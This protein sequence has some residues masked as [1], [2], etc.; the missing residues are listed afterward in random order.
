MSIV[1]VKLLATLSATLIAYAL[2]KA[3]I[4]IFAELTS[5]TRDLPGPKS[6]SLFYGNL[7]ELRED[8][9]SYVR[10]LFSPC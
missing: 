5:P 6:T 4:V 7:K 1:I 2:Y 8:V 10:F 9:C 3:S